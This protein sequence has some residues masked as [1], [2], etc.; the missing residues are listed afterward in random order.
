M[1]WDM[2]YPLYISETSNIK[3]TIWACVRVEVAVSV[4]G[5]VGLKV[6]QLEPM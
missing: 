6:W 1:Q 4:H 5:Y 3:T 2:S